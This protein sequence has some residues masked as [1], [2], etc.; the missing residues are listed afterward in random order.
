MKKDLILLHGA[1]GSKVQFEELGNLLKDDFNIYKFDFSGHGGLEIPES[2]FSIELFSKDLIEFIKTNNLSEI[3]I[4]GYSMGG[5]VALF[6]YLELLKEN[7]N[8]IKKIITLATKF[9]W[10]PET[11][12]KESSMLNPETIELKIPKFAEMLKKRHTEKLWKEVLLKTS[13]MMIDLGN[14]PELKE[15]NYSKIEIPVLITIGDN[16][17]MVS[18]E[19]S[20][21]IA[22]KIK[23]CKFKILENTQH[24]IEKVDTEKLSEEIRNFIN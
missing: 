4:F 13:D 15:E 2:R 1:L 21:N 22:E 6:A 20:Q 7:I 3:Y 14:K 11:S 12:K 5:Y 23:N 16:D 9:D 8:P 24:P 10:N 18:I 19:E 17:N